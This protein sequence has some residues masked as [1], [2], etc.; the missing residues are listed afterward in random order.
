MF[1]RL[2]V[3]SGVRFPLHVVLYRTSLGNLH[4]HMLVTLDERCAPRTSADVDRMTRA[5][6]PDPRLEPALFSMV[7][8][9]HIHGPCDTG[10]CICLDAQGRCTKKFP[11]AFREE[12]AV[13]ENGYAEPSRPDDGPR[14]EYSNGKVAH[15]G[16]VVPYNPHLLLEFDAHVN[17]ELCGSKYF[18]NLNNVREGN[19]T[20]EGGGVGAN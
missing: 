3:R 1:T 14:I 18:L 10:D 8:Q 2:R 9:H 11:K 16:F 20:W 6:I 12:S 15:N 19:R 17:V 5:T 4:M 13:G 7:K